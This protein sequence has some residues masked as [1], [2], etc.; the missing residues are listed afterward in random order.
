[1]PQGSP[2]RS[3]M[4]VDPTKLSTPRIFLVRMLV[5]L[6]LCALVGVV[7]YKQII[8]AFFANPGLNALIGAVLLIGVILAFRQVVRLYP[9]V[10]WVNNFRIADPGLAVPRHPVLL[11]P[12]AAILGRERTGR[13]SISQQTMRHLLDSI[14]TRLDEARDISRYM[15]G[16]LVF[17]G[18]LGTFWGLIETVGSVGKVIDGLKVG[19]DAGALFDTLKGGLAAPLSG[20]GI[21]FSSS[22]FGL[23]G[24]LILGFLDLQSSQA[25]NRFY[26]DLEDWL[27]GTVREYG[28]TGDTGADL[29]VA[30]ERLRTA[31]EEGSNRGATA[32]MA[33]LAEAIQ[34][35]VA[36]MR[37]EQQMIREWADGQGEQNREI[38]RL[39]ERLARQ[40]EKS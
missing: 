1:M 4:G 38:K 10:S 37:T 18:L 8:M 36:H 33:N 12:M 2:P 16:L 13:M 28:G 27:A 14:A 26:T 24:S 30:I 15:T 5:F 35:L 31:M 22:L 19:G 3:A 20:M 7:L 23:A 9:E 40:T 21:S 6:V 17:L 11:A 39:L 34:G 29:S 32:A 25:Q